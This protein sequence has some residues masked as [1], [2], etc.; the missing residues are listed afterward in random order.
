MFAVVKKGFSLARSGV[1]AVWARTLLEAVRLAINSKI[2]RFGEVSSL[3]EQSGGGLAMR[4]RLVGV[5]DELRLAVDR[6][7]IAEDGASIALSGFA[8]S[9]PLATKL[10]EEL[11]AGKTW[12]V[13]DPEARLVLRKLGQAL[14]R[15]A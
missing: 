14:S 10:L 9:V 2:A 7:D 12:E 5:A 4:L 11:C 13:G 3:E 1:D 8:S 15:Q 6:V